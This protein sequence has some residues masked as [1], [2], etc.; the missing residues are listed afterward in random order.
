MKCQ[1]VDSDRARGM[2]KR[3]NSGFIAFLCDN[4]W[5]LGVQLH[6]LH[7]FFTL[8]VFWDSLRHRVEKWNIYC[9]QKKSSNQLITYLL[10]SLEKALFSRN[11]CYL[12]SMYEREREWISVISTMCTLFWLLLHRLKM[13]WI[14]KFYQNIFPLQPYTPE[15]S[16]IHPI[17]F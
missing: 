7:P 17:S 12:K 5:K 13:I 1:N 6:L 2:Q 15:T 11:F 9:H 4:F 3:N 10:I 16:K 8:G 14:L